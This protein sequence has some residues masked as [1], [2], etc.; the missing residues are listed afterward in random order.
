M[1]G[2]SGQ[3]VCVHVRS[4][5]YVGSAILGVTWL[6]H[7][8]LIHTPVAGACLCLFVYVWPVPVPPGPVVLALD[9]CTIPCEFS[10]TGPCLLL[11]GS[12]QFSN[13][14]V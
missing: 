3:K 8:S 1:S 14:F 6:T 7:G 13:P 5:N 9:A 2:Y 12:G 10:G 4:R 11:C